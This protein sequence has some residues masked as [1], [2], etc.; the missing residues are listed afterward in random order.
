MTARGSSCVIA[1]DVLDQ[2]R[3]QLQVAAGGARPTWSR[4]CGYRRRGLRRVR[5]LAVRAR[6]G[7]DVV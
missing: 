4:G 7:T 1:K 6:S 5:L 3:I 2:R